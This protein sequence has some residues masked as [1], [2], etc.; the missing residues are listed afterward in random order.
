MNKKHYTAVVSF[1]VQPEKLH[2]VIHG[3]NECVQRYTDSGTEFT[4]IAQEDDED[5][6]AKQ[7]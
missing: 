3:I 2:E 6:D 7:L 4:L 1:T 5:F